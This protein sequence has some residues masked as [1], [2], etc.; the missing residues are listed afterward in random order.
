MVFDR[1][2]ARL[3]VVANGRWILKGA[4]ALD[5]R[6]GSRTRTTKD[7]DLGRADDED[8]ATEDFIAAQKA[9]LDDYFVFFIE[10]TDRLEDLE[11]A[12]AVRYHVSCDLAGR[13]FDDIVVDVAFGRGEMSGTET[14]RGPDLLGFAEIEAVEVPAIP[15]SRHVAE[16]VH[17]YTRAYGPSGRPSSR[18]KDLVDLALIA[19]EATFDAV[20]L[21]RALRTTFATRG[22]QEL[23]RRLPPPP[24][25]WTFPYRKLAGEIGIS[26]RIED[27]Y[28]TAAGM[29]DPLLEDGIT[30]GTWDREARR[31][32]HEA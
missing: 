12:A 5:F 28:A 32:R 18:V 4:I 8:A 17:A 24:E 30:T 13:R 22:V 11:E 1:L 15:L 19:S 2:L 3:V 6:F 10:R 20:D 29:L 25:D 21:L 7:I 14:L 9:D 26:A 16:K 27:G 23:P 31:W